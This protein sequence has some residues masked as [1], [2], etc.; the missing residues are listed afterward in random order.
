[1]NGPFDSTD[2]V[3]AQCSIF[4]AVDG[5]DIHLQ[6]VPLYTF[7]PHTRLKLPCFIGS[8]PIHFSRMVFFSLVS[9]LKWQ[10][11]LMLLLALWAN[12]KDNYAANLNNI[13][14]Q[15]CSWFTSFWLLTEVEIHYLVRLWV[16]AILEYSF[17]MQV[18]WVV[19][20]I[21]KAKCT[22]SVLQENWKSNVLHC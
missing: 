22:I 4:I 17:L 5:K 9:G 2:G 11:I 16:D 6:T 3:F 20:Y 12:V 13:L 10:F 18:V 8:S 1:M 21:L 15:N 19:C 7:C 14:T